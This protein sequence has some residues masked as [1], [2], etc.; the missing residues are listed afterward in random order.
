VNNKLHAGINGLG[1]SARDDNLSLMSA[2]LALCSSLLFGTGDYIG[3]HLSKKHNVMAVTGVVQVVG[4]LTGIIL[5]LATGT[6]IAPTISW[7]GYFLPG[8]CAGVIGFIGLNAF[9]AGLA[10]G[11]MGVVSP[12]SSLSV[13]IPVIYSLI[14]GERPSGLAITGMI[15]AMLGAFFG[16]GPEIRGGLSPKPLLFAAIAALCFGTAV[17][18][19]T[20]GA[21]ANVLMTATTMRAPNMFILAFLAIRFKTTGGFSKKSLGFLLFGGIADFMANVTLGQAST[22]GLVSASVVLASLYP[23]VTSVLAFRFSH[24]RLHKLQYVG[25]ICAVAGVSL[26]SMG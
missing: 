14:H 6:W 18:F 23:V 25:I 20:I 3:G 11:R 9:F 4:F 15:I 8:V 1:A 26:I 16:S 12:I 13:M 5:L 10:T 22:M 17:I 24:E 21:Q 7:S 19:L 2:L